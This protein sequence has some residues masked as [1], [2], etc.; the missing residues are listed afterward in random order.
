V[1]NGWAAICLIL[2]VV[3]FALIAVALIAVIAVSLVKLNDKLDRLTNLAEPVAAK[4]TDTLESVQ[5]VTTSVGEKAD[6]IL[7]RSIVT[8]DAVSASVE[9]TTKVVEHTVTNPLIKLSSVIAGVSKSI[10]VYVGHERTN[11]HKK[12]PKE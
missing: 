7:T 9:R 6:E 5:R 2:I 11:G 4:V 12:E 8:T 1:I 3:L 10:S